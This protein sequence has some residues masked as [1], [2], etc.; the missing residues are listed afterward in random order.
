MRIVAVVVT[1]VCVSA[2]NAANTQSA[3]EQELTVQGGWGQEQ[4][5]LDAQ[6]ILAG[7]AQ[8]RLRAEQQARVAR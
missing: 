1:I 2:C 7:M 8:A 6:A 3:S 5:V 4:A